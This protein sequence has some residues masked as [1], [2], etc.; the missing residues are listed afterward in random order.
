MGLFIRMI[1]YGL[2]AG[3]ATLGV[4]TFD[5]VAGTVTISLN[6][7]ELAVGGVVG[8]IATFA[9]SRIAKARGGKT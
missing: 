6:S 1:L 5:P 9:V 7:L 3:A 4:A 8:Y 2:A